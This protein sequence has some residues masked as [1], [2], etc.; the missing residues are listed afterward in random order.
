MNRINFGSANAF[1][2][3]VGNFLTSDLLLLMIVVKKS[4]NKINFKKIFKETNYETV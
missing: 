2:A 1:K 3:R 4:E